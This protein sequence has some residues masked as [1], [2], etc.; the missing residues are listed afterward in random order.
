MSLANLFYNK[1]STNNKNIIYVLDSL[2]NIS[3]N[4]KVIDKKRR[5]DFSLY[6]I[7]NS[8]NIYQE[9]IHMGCMPIIRGNKKISTK[10]MA[11]INSLWMYIEYD[12]HTDFLWA[13]VAENLEAQRN[14]HKKMIFIR[15]ELLKYI[16]DKQLISKDVYT[17][18]LNYKVKSLSD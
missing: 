7:L 6:K 15:K 4:A 13:Q 1:D 9:V 10:F 16:F 17:R 11:F 5:I 18:E 3:I 2:L 14:A 12:I 8:P